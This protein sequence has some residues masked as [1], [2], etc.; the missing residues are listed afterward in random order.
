[1]VANASMARCGVQSNLVP[2]LKIRIQ[3]ACNVGHIS[4]V[5]YG[6]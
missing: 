3:H 6:N 4:S 5:A 1:M 2:L